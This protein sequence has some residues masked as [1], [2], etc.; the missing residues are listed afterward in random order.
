MSQPPA[1]EKRP[2]EPAKFT[3]RPFDL[4]SEDHRAAWRLRDE[5][6]RKP[7]GTTVPHVDPKDEVRSHHLGCFLKSDEGELL[8]GTLMLTPWDET[9]VKMRQVAVASEY[10]G[11]GLGASLVTF[12]EE[13]AREKGFTVMMAHARAVV[14]EFY[15]RLG[16]TIGEDMFIEVTIPHY[17]ISKRL[18]E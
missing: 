12:A 14:V 10:R 5:I 15:R 3:C 13:F 9:T 1:P 18:V 6:L 16:Y 11:L 2:L 17:H 7:L 8:V 4:D